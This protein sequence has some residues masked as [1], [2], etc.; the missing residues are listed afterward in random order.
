MHSTKS[1]STVWRNCHSLVSGFPLNTEKG[2]LQERRPH[3]QWIP[4]S[5][6]RSF[7]GGN[8]LGDL[9]RIRT[10]VIPGF[11]CI[12]LPEIRDFKLVGFAPFSVARKRFESFFWANPRDK[13][14]TLA[15]FP[16]HH[17]KTPLGFQGCFCW[18]IQDPRNK[19]WLPIQD[20]R[21]GGY[22]AC[23][24]HFPVKSRKIVV[25]HT[26]VVELSGS[27]ERGPP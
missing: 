23:P 9:F 18:P 14:V 15:G 2:S 16:S 17:P 8:G 27:P 25:I 11:P 1:G 5:W 7:K 24:V 3:A 19:Q 10:M 12:Q 20:P 22:P 4:I 13:R 21:N 6:S 26:L